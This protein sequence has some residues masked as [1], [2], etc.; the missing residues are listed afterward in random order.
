MRHEGA[1]LP[2]ILLLFDSP[3]VMPPQITFNW[4]T[5]R[6]LSIVHDEMA[7]CGEEEEEVGWPIK[8]YCGERYAEEC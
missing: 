1:Q 4:G 5:K 7:P 2:I 6:N 3:T 8:S